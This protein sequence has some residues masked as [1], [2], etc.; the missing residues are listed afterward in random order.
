MSF[1]ITNRITELTHK[2]NNIKENKVK[3]DRIEEAK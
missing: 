1:E 2:L 3:D